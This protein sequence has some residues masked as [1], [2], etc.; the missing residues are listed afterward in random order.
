MARVAA[1]RGHVQE[2]RRGLSFLALFLCVLAV[3]SCRDTAPRALWSR[4]SRASRALTADP[5]QPP[6]PPPVCPRPGD[7]PDPFPPDLPSGP[8]A[9]IGALS[10]AFSVTASGDAAYSIPLPVLPGRAGIEPD[11][12]IT[13]TSSG[14]DGPLGHGFALTGLSA[15]TRCPRNLAQDGAIWPVHDDHADA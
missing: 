5:S 10:G 11:L 13:Y 14:D 3:A 8:T 7:V 12:D 9:E 6:D 1:A 4:T 15:I 2:P